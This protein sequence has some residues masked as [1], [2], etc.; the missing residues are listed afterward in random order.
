MAAPETA[1]A[2]RWD[3]YRR[4][5]GREPLPAAVLDLDAVDANAARLAG[6]ARAHGKRLRVASKSLR[7]PDLLRYVLDRCGDVAGG[8]MTYTAGETAWLAAQGY[9]DLLLAY[10]TVHPRDVEHLAAANARGATAAVVVDAL[11][12]LAALDTGARA[13]GTTIPV[14]VELD[15]AWR[16]SPSVGY[17]GARRSPLGTVDAVCDLVA[18]VAAHPH[19]RFHGVMAYEAHIAGLPDRGQ[20]ALGPVLRWIKSR[21]RPQ[22]AALRGRVVQT[23]RDRGHAL[24]LVN[25]GGTGSLD[26]ASRE[27]ALTEVT[28]GSG[29]VDSHLFDGYDG[30]G[31]T[32]AAGFA[33]QAVRRPRA[34]M[35][36]CHG[37][38]YIASGAAGADRLP[39]P[40]LPEGMSL[41]A[42]EGAGEVQTPLVLASGVAIALGDPVFFRHA[43]AGELAEHFTSYVCIRGDRVVERFATYRGLGQCFLG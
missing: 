43:K 24:A 28:A 16:P 7:C 10:P 35:I 30:L 23:L 1:T 8:V 32:P 36:T 22:A 4:A 13:A 38:G 20:G 5:L 12:H 41:V 26:G 3:R 15:V 17:I 31:L 19:L 34:G 27:P 18:R 21:A 25:G 2:T 11:E 42:H 9:T 33:L 37:G 6:I 39:I 29:F 40:W 14:V